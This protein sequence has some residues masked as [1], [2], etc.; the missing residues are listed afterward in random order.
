MTFS[1]TELKSKSEIQA[2]KKNNVAVCK[3]AGYDEYYVL[4]S[5]DIELE[6]KGIQVEV[7]ASKSPLKSAFK[8]TW[9]FWFSLG[10]SL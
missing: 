3:S 7:G 5:M 4:P 9:N 10:D 6:N 2:L 1:W 8:K